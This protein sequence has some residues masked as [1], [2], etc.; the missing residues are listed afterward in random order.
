MKEVKPK[1]KHRQFSIE[2]KVKAVRILKENGYDYGATARETGVSRGTLRI[3]ND[4]FVS[5]INTDKVQIIAAETEI[6]ITQYKNAFIKKHFAKLEDTTV[7]AINRAI[8][9]LKREKDL[10]KVNGTIK[11]LGDMIMKLTQTQSET[12][13][14]TTNIVRQSIIQ[15]NN[16]YQK[17]N[18]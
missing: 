9:L 7:L 2:D 6:A 15:L 11:V 13:A 3:W 12:Q 18:S 1:R 5:D 17:E 4:R 8:V 14:P 10:T 16:L